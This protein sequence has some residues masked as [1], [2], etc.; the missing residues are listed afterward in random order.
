MSETVFI[1]TV[2]EVEGWN[3]AAWLEA[4]TI[5]AWVDIDGD[6]EGCT[7]E[8]FVRL[9]FPGLTTVDDIL[10]YHR[11]W[12][13]VAG[14]PRPKK[15]ASVS[16]PTRFFPMGAEIKRAT[17]DAWC[18]YEITDTA[19]GKLRYIGRTVSP[20]ARFATHRK[21]FGPSVTMTVIGRY[22]TG[23]EVGRAELTAIKERHPSDN[24]RWSE[25]W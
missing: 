18:L 7:P 2:E 14:L 12:T 25:A 9:G 24:I 4:A 17:G 22:A 20:H 19:T 8:Q 1:P 5:A 11:A 15:G 16:L 13:V 10:K 6:G 23:A 21:R 3:R